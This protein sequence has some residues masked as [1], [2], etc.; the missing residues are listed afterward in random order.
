MMYFFAFMT[1]LISL[2]AAIVIIVLIIKAI[3]KRDERKQETIRM[4]LERG[5]YDRELV[6]PKKKGMASLGWGMVFLAIGVGLLIG[7]IF[8]GVASQGAMATAIV[9]FLG[10]ALIVFYFARRTIGSRQG[11]GSDKPII[12]PGATPGAAREIGDETDA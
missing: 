8:L 12:L 3:Q 1:S 5:I 11:N 2:G 4:M 9:S 10:V 6:H 7:F